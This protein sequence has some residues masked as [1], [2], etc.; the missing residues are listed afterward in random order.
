M[1]QLR[2]AVIIL[3]SFLLVASCR[4][5]SSNETSSPA[6][7]PVA[8]QLTGKQLSQSYC[9]SCHQFPEP[10]LLDKVTWQRGVLPQMAL[11]MG[12]SGN[13]MA[14]YM[15]ISHADEL[16]RLMEA[17][18]FP[19]TPLLH[20]TDWQKIVDYYASEAPAKLLPQP[21]HTAVQVGLPLFQVQQSKQAIDAFVTLLRFDSISH[22]I[23]VG[24]GR[25]NLY[26]LNQNLIRMDSVHLDS[27][28][29]DLH[30]QSDGSFDLL[31]VGVLNPNDRQM[32]T[33]RHFT[34]TGIVPPALLSGLQRPVRAIP[35]DLNR[36]GL[37][38][39]VIC[40]FGNHLGKLTWHERLPEGYREHVLDSLPGA[41][42]LII[43]D[44]N[45]DQ[46]PDIIALLTQGNEQVSVYYNQRNG[47]FRKETVLR[48]P[49]VYGSS[50]LAVADVDHDGDLDLIYTNGDNA[51]YSIVLKPY[52]GIRIFLNDGRFHFRQAWFYPMY[53]VTQTIVRDFDQDGDDDIATIAH[54]PDFSH[55]PNEGF[56]YFENQGNLR[57]LPRT[58]PDA[59]RGRWLIME[60]GD[61][62]QDGDD[63]IL[64]GSFFRPTGPE[65]MDLMNRWRKPGTG[66]LLLK[67]NLKK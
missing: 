36:D 63:D 19:E 13:S 14:E 34:Q 29:T 46:W 62:D 59:E 22:R 45:N 61:V 64:L 51:D 48:F 9:G 43:R 41:R 65:H 37:D 2:L 52:H 38:D 39:V 28:A 53:G 42:Q 4:S 27:P 55:Q 54:F 31:T 5:T 32:G 10:S 15:R 26:A 12:Q 33:W 8:T 18:V 60:T 49:S 35:T 3:Y 67:N 56:V 16:T 40:Q 17:K 30:P 20:T 44:L 57:F 6:T 21:A 47:Q 23:W 7:P 11:R 58:F 24:D 50:D 1:F 25:S 66:I